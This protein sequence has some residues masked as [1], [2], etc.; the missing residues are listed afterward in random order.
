MPQMP[1]AAKLSY[2]FLVAV[3]AHSATVFQVNVDTSLLIG[4]AARPFFLDFQL[5]DGSGT[6]DGNT[7]IAQQF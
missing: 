5:T 4:Q 1:L 3:T 2:L 6:G 7:S